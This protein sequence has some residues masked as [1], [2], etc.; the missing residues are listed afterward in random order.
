MSVWEKDLLWLM[1]AQ[2]HTQGGQRP[3]QSFVELLQPLPY[4]WQRPFLS[5]AA[6]GYGGIGQPMLQKGL[7]AE[8]QILRGAVGVHVFA[9]P[10]IGRAH[11]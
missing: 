5:R 11:V 3:L 10:Q 2:N 7:Q 6:G 4:L 1:L 9:V 8:R